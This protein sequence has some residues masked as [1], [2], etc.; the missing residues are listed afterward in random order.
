[1]DTS[2]NP[3][4]EL[5]ELLGPV[6]SHPWAALI[7]QVL[8]W[9]FRRFCVEKLTLAEG[10]LE[11]SLCDDILELVHMYCARGLEVVSMEWFTPENIEKVS[12]P[13]EAYM[14]F[15]VK[16]CNELDTS[17][18]AN[19]DQ[20][21]DVLS[22][23]LDESMGEIIAQWL[24]EKHTS[25][26]IFPIHVEDDDEFTEAQ[27]S[28]LIN[29]LLT[30]CYKAPPPPSKPPIS[31]LW[32]LLSHQKKFPELPPEALSETYY[33]EAV[34]ELVIPPA[35]PDEMVPETFEQPSDA[36]EPSPEPSPEAP[37][38]EPPVT[39]AKALARRRTLHKYG[40]KSQ[41]PRV[42]TRKTHPASY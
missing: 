2:F 25:L 23:F 40:R 1:M 32:Y 27:F 9:S 22:E 36:P 17:I 6:P 35:P 13:L 15:F 21:Q 37:E 29:S 5:L 3:R 11:E 18:E 7:P 10:G 14:K 28:A 33:P 24:D 20:R 34:S 39:V 38:P 42:K 31:M 8:L 16:F 4:K 26:L 41:A 30:Y 19:N 12:S